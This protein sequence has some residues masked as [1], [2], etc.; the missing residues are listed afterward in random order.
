MMSRFHDVSGICL[1]SLAEGLPVCFI[2]VLLSKECLN[3]AASNR[4]SF[5][6]VYPLE[7]FSI[8]FIPL[9]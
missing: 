9:A 7:I 1:C 8:P 2:G 4:A 3:I 6:V 5:S